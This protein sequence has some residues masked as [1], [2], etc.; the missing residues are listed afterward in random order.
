MAEGWS[1][2]MV[3]AYVIADN[4]L[5]ENGGWNRELLAE[6]LA[7]LQALGFDKLLTGFSDK[8]IGELLLHAVRI[9]TKHCRSRPSR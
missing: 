9:R 5:S 2:E 1:P 7:E 4:K 6:E 3:R 8:E